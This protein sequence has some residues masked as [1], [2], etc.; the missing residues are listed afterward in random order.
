[1]GFCCAAAGLLWAGFA[2][3]LTD[4]HPVFRSIDTPG[5]PDQHVESIVEDPHGYVWIG[6]R[7]GLVRHE[8]RDM[9]F[10]PRDPRHPNALP[11]VN[12]TSLLAH[13]SGM[14]WAGVS[15]QGVVEIG[16]DLIPRRHLAPESSGGPLP[17][18]QVW[19]MTEDCEGRIWLAFMRGGLARYDPDSEKLE[20]IA[21]NE[22]FGLDPTAFQISVLVDAQC[23]LWLAQSSRL[24]VLDES[25]GQPIFLSIA[26]GAPNP[27]E[28]FLA[29]GEHSQ[30]GV[31]AGQGQQLLRLNENDQLPGGFE[32]VP[33]FS[34][35]GVVSGMAE[36]PDARLVLAT[37]AGPY[38]IDPLSL[39]SQ[40]IDA[41]PD[42]PD[43]L[44]DPHLSGS[45]LVD[46]E[47]GVWL[48]ISRRGL[49]YLPPDHAL[50]SR[51]QRG[52]RDDGEFVL[53]RI[54]AVRPG[55]TENSFWI[56]GR[57]GIQRLNLGSG[58]VEHA[59]DM[60]P[61]FPEEMSNFPRGFLDLLERP[62]G[63]LILDVRAIWRLGWQLNEIEELLHH[64]RLSQTSLTFMYPDGS[65]GL[66]VGTAS[67]GLQRLDLSS[68]ELTAY[69]PD[70]PSPR[71]LPESLTQFMKHDADGNLLLAAGSNIYRYYADTGFVRLAAVDQGRIADL[72][73][74]PDGSTWVAGSASLSRWQL[75]GDRAE[76]LMDYDIGNLVERAALRQVFQLSSNEVWLVLSNG[77][78]RLNPLT[79][80]SRLFTRSDG[81]PAGEFAI[82]SSLEAPDGRILIG[83]TQGL[84]LM[85]P[86][87]QVRESM[88]PLIHLT[89]VLAGDLD[90]LLV[91]GVRPRLNMDWRQSSVRFEFSARTFAA[92]ER[93]RYRALLEGWDDDWIELQD[94]GQMY[95]S[96]LRPGLYRFRVQ[97]ATADGVWNDSD[98]SITIKLA[99]PPWAAPAAHLS[100]AVILAGGLAIGWGSARRARRRRLYLQEVQQKRSMAERQRQLLQRLNDN[101]EPVPLARVINQEMLRLTGAVSACFAYAHEQ[102]PR[103]LVETPHPLGLTRARWRQQINAVDGLSA[104]AVDLEADREVVASVLLQAPPEGFRVDHEEQLALLVGLAGQALHNSLLLQRVK[105]LADHAEA[106]NRAKSEFLAT[107]SHEIRTPLHGVMGMAELLHE[108]ETEPDRLELISTLRASGRQLQRVIDDVLDLSQVEAGRLSVKQESFEL[109]SVLE[110]VVDLHAANA[111][112]KRLDLR[113]SV[114]ADL[115]VV[116]C[117]DADRLGQIL[118]NL[119][120]NAV[121]FTE[122]GAIELAVM[123][124]A[125]GWLRFAVRDSG[126]GI[127]PQNRSR[128]FQ[129]F[130]QLD[131]SIR[132]LYGGSGLG[133]AI[134]RSL[135]E[136]MGGNLEL[137]DRRWP[138]STFMLSLP[139]QAAPA[140]KPLTRLLQ[141]LCLVALVEPSSYRVLL[142]CARRWGFRIRSGWQSMPEPGA[143]VLA[144]ARLM[145]RHSGLQAWLETS[146]CGFLLE[147]PFDRE[148]HGHRALASST[149]SLRWP[150]QEGRLVAALMDWVLE[151]VR[152]E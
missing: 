1:M 62:D 12:I 95:Y 131:A 133:L 117:G 119:L 83:G 13:T 46:R 150:L 94:Q 9:S 70:Q 26:T 89:R 80:Q 61:G 68:L 66:W 64:S 25:G 8:G 15:G 21:Q 114:Q 86:E 39:H 52:F 84:V 98:D 143:I 51:L 43:A 77:V 29:L 123:R 47:G 59:R 99:P 65:D 78:A 24:L 18:G 3:A 56:G 48:A 31:I 6:T 100:Y 137:I 134:C 27:A 38:F 22:Q 144:D 57:G 105:R 74:A 36:L 67:E 28:I 149:R 73:L 92:P 126:P 108:R 72:A 103:D 40:R 2:A 20:L 75:H 141:D 107:M 54:S 79:G 19:S 91:P 14:V 34:A 136:G 130:T 23:R 124:D 121:K 4:F 93:V 151:G 87:Q 7:G 111:A 127:E 140:P 32:A 44:P 110:Q 116:M 115:P 63:L 82:R 41:R 88:A 30:F 142:R 16:P 11:D 109:V 139:C 148:E 135:A 132:R 33:L 76:L 122:R 102:M 147:S 97:V 35:S 145:A 37:S 138:G 69:G 5:L 50:F 42:L 81:L 104:Q 129:S 120:S 10:L 146:A 106:A 49:V 71:Y 85:N 53:E 125:Q 45:V 112:R 101:L 17:H 55:L 113:L 60:F 128:L 152:Q 90:L 118:G 96:N 58:T